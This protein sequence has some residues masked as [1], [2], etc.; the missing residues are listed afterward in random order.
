LIQLPKKE[1]NYIKK[2]NALKAGQGNILG[3]PNEPSDKTKS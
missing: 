1:N 3:K 2:G